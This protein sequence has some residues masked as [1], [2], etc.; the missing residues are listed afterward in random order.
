MTEPPA[1]FIHAITMGKG[2]FIRIE[3]NC[4]PPKILWTLKA[5]L[6]AVGIGFQWSTIKRLVEQ[7]MHA[8]RAEAHVTSMINGLIGAEVPPLPSQQEINDI[9]AAMDE[10]AQEAA[11]AEAADAADEE[12]TD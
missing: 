7:G 2:G 11:E 5:L 8:E 12:D 9:R 10:I 4:P 6:Q 1:E 3:E